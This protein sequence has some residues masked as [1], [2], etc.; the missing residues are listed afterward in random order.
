MIGAVT[1]Y[2]YRDYVE[3]IRKRLEDFKNMKLTKEL[4]Y[5]VSNSFKH[6]YIYIYIINSKGD[7]I[8]LQFAN[9]MNN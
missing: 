1:S 9:V 4:V 7:I 2:A 5:S 3:N 8:V 6:I